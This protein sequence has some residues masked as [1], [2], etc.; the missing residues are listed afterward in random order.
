MKKNKKYFWVVLLLMLA[1]LASCAD[2]SPVS[3]LEEEIADD[4][5]DVKEEINQ[6]EDKYSSSAYWQS[7][8]EACY[9]GTSYESDSWCCSN[10]GYQC[11]YSSSSY[12][13]GN[14]YYSSSSY[15][16]ESEKCRLG[17][18]SYSDSYC[19]SYYGYQCSYSSS[20]YTSESEKCRLGSSSY[21]NSYCCSYY[22]Y[23]CGI[24]ESKTM[25]FTLTRYEQKTSGWDG[26]QNAGDPE[27]Y[28]N[29]YTYSEGVSAQTLKTGVMLDRSDLTYWTGEKTTTLELIQGI[30]SLKV[31]PHIIDEDMSAHDDYSSGYCYS[32]NKVGTIKDYDDVIEQSDYKNTDASLEW[33]WYLY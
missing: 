14:S 6:D 21:S 18:S 16:S 19:C 33:E 5:Y 29:I 12:Y 4:I 1:F 9:Y 28:F 17:T 10:F 8:K 27:V 30:D 11:S 20:S 23:Q 32:I 31:C 15:A 25:V 13:Y 7:E 22:G 3:S 26:L 2:D 24:A